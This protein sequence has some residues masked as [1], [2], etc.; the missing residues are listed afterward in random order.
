MKKINQRFK[1]NQNPDSQGIHDRAEKMQ[2]IFMQLM[3][4]QFDPNIAWTFGAAASVVVQSATQEA[5]Q[6]IEDKIMEVDSK[7]IHHEERIT[8]LENALAEQTKTF[9]GMEQRIT[10]GVSKVVS[11]PTNQNAGGQAGGGGKFR[12]ADPATLQISST[13]TC[14]ASL[15]RAQTTPVIIMVKFSFPLWVVVQGLCDVLFRH[16]LICQVWTLANHC[17][18]QV[19]VMSVSASLPG[20]FTLSD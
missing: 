10:T 1:E 8:R 11:Q 7:V 15:R 3:G 18:V 20:L 13:L 16:E 6:H 5:V 19:K 9:V 17:A 4:S 14:A 2:G 12:P